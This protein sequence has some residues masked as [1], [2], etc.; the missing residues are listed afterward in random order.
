MVRVFTREVDGQTTEVELDPD[1][2]QVKGNID[3]QAIRVAE[4]IGTVAELLAEAEEDQAN[5]Q[6]EYRAWRGAQL[7]RML[8]REPKIPE[9][10]SKAAYESMPAFLEHKKNMAQ[11]AGDIEHLRTFLEALK[12]KAEMVRVRADFMLTQMAKEQG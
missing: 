4:M 11:C 5:M 2:L 10:K 8:N 3:G 1:W 12:V 7:T 9:W 6:A